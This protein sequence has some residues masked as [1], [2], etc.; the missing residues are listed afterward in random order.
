M[1]NLE[2]LMSALGPDADIST[3]P[4]CVRYSPDSVVQKLM[5][6]ARHGCCRI[7]H[8]EALVSSDVARRKTAKPSAV[9][10]QRLCLVA[11]YVPFSRTAALSCRTGSE[12]S[13]MPPPFSADVS[14]GASTTPM[15]PGGLSV[16]TSSQQRPRC[17]NESGRA[18][19]L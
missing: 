8:R 7:R 1:F 11:S 13:R 18:Q 12:A 17:L 10:S 14:S 2:P 3:V 6:P 4:T 19:K 15:R 16:A 9:R 5:A